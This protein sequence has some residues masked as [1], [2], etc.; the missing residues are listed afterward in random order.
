MIADFQSKL[1]KRVLGVQRRLYSDLFNVSMGLRRK[2]DGT[3]SQSNDISAVN[4]KIG[5][6]FVAYEVGVKKGIIPW[7][8]RSVLKLL[9]IN[10]S[11][12]RSISRFS[13]TK[14]RNK[15]NKAFLSQL[16]YNL[17]KGT[18]I[19]GSWL[20]GLSNANDAKLSVMRR[21]SSSIMSGLSMQNFTKLFKAD[22]LGSS[23]LNLQRHWDTHT[24]TMFMSIDRNAQRYYGKQLKLKHYIFSGTLKDN[25]RGFCAARL[26]RIYTEDEINKWQG[27]SWQGK[28][29]GASV[30]DVLGGYNCRHVL[31]AVSDAIVERL[32][33]SRGKVNTYDTSI[34][35]A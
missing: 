28:I 31:S 22:F 11:Y 23:G 3:L 29:E 8:V 4:S 34:V 26:N 32:V 20:A 18:I 21:F 2:K 19:K 14:V 15:A 10:Y 6:V 5:R 33:K 12:F 9:K 24:R 1:E 25:S 13:I 7:M 17:E 35:I 16:G 30:W 27:L